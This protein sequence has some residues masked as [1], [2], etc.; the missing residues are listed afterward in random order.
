[1]VN[2]WNITQRL[3][4]WEMWLRIFVWDV[5]IT[6]EM[7]SKKTQKKGSTLNRQQLVVIL[8]LEKG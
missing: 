7:V 3:L 2:H 6:I 8:R 5:C 1:M 4:N